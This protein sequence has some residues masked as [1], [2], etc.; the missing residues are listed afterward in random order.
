MHSYVL[1][2]VCRRII[3]NK[4]NNDVN[5]VGQIKMKESLKNIRNDKEAKLKDRIDYVNSICEENIELFDTYTHSSMLEGNRR[6]EERS[7]NLTI[8]EM[9]TLLLRSS[10]AESCRKGEYSFYETESDYRRLYGIGKNSIST[11]IEEREDIVYDRSTLEDSTE[12]VA[13]LAL[14]NFEN[15]SD[16]EKKNLLMVGLKEKNNNEYENLMDYLSSSYD[17]VIDLLD[18]EKDREI[19]ECIAKGM[20]QKEI[21]NEVGI[22]QQN[23]SKRIKRIYSRKI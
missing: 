9:G 3:K 12:R 8:E 1:T 22:A 17:Y 10:D 2:F 20:S 18:D 14:F 13:T 11:N 6:F 16:K 4:G 7:L 21:S 5:N 19:V 15:M 23:V